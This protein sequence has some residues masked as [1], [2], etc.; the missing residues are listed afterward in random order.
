M[1][2]RL[3]YCREVR[4]VARADHYLRHSFLRAQPRQREARQ[5]PC[6]SRRDRPQVV[7]Q[8]ER[9]AGQQILI[10]LR[11]LGHPRADWIRLTATVFASEPAAR[12]RAVSQVGNATSLAHVQQLGLVLASQQREAVLDGLRVA[13]AQRR[14]QL[15]SAEV[16]YPVTA[17]EP[18]AGS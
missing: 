5:G 17:D 7:Q 12:E 4:W 11:P 14:G 1:R 13:H 18:G 15:G 16:A 8:I 2:Q 10:S 3:G 9:L 6:A